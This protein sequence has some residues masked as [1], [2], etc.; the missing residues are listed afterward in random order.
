MAVEIEAKIKVESLDSVRAKLNGAGAKFMGDF[1]ETNAIFDTED[2]S[3]L[4]AD[5]GLR[6]RFAKNIADG[7]ELCTITYKGPRK[8]SALKSR[9]E[10]E[11]TVSSFEDAVNLLNQLNFHQV[12]SFQ[13]KRQV[14]ELNNCEIALDELPHLGTFVEIEGTNEKT[15]HR[16]QEALGLGQ[17]PI[18]KTSYVGLMIT[19]LRDRGN[20]EQQAH[21][22]AA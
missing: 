10:T 9:E 2:R 14:W 22:S 1:M 20:D 7:S 12:L 19:F 15:I 6:V 18:V 13:K 16:A 8:H 3:L 5:Q 4:A 17:R 21:F 11:L